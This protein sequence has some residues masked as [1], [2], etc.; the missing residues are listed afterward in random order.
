MKFKA[1][2]KYVKIGIT[3]FLVVVASTCFYYLMFHGSN[4]KQGIDSIINILMPV[5]LGLIMAYLLTPILNFLEYKIL[6][7][8]C[9][10]LKIKESSKRNYIVRVISVLITAAL[11]FAVI[12]LVISMMLSQIVPS[13]LNI[14]SNFDK[15]INNITKWIDKLLEDNPDAGD[16]IIKLIDKYSVELENWFNDH[17]LSKTSEL[18]KTVSLSV[19]GVLKFFWN[20]IIGFII[21]IY[22]LASKEKFSGQAKKLIFALFDR[23]TA[24]IVINNFRFT[25]KTFIGFISGKVLDSLIIGILCFVGTSILKTPYAALVSLFI[26]VTNIIPFFGPYIGAIPSIILIFVVDPSHPLNCLYF[27]IFILILQQFDGNFIGPKILGNSTGL[28]G[29]WVIF[30]I[31]LFGGLFGI[32]GMIVGVPIFAVIYAAIRSLVNALL[33]RKKMPTDSKDYI[34]VSSVDQNGVLHNYIPEY[35]QKKKNREKSSYGKRFMSNME[36][37]SEQV[38]PVQMELYA[39][40]P[41][42]TPREQDVQSNQPS[43]LAKEEKEENK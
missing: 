30:A 37:N 2:S 3:L 31:I 15:Y 32:G 27:A 9:N 41:I 11:F 14:F 33:M 26:G 5:V 40:V 12:Y 8:L 35:K 7:P 16:N 43:Q 22:V 38:Q 17:V 1:N 13:V 18:I 25:H 6:F 42:D 10:R 19:I 24:N 34:Y 23:G 28:T 20:F 21:S 4:F 29:F 39:E 36:S